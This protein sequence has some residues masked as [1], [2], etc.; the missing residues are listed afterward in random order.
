VIKHEG[1]ELHRL[2]PA[3]IAAHPEF[4]PWRRDESALRSPGWIDAEGRRQPPRLIRNV[5]QP[6]DALYYWN[7]PWG[8]LSGSSGI[9]VVRG[10]HVIETFTIWVS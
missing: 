4:D 10:G 5:C 9:A 8:V 7:G 6:T 1:L 2:T 3:V